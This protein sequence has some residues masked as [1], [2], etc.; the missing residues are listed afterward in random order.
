MFA[1]AAPGTWRGSSLFSRIDD[2]AGGRWATVRRALKFYARLALRR[3]SVD[4]CIRYFHA[5]SAE[6]AQQYPIELHLRPLRPY[7]CANLSVRRRVDCVVWHFN[8][9]HNHLPPEFLRGAPILLPLP[10]PEFP[11]V[12]LVLRH[13]ASQS[14]E[15]ELSLDLMFAGRRV[16]STNFS[17]VSGFVEEG[18]RPGQSAVLVGGFQGVRGTEHEVREIGA[19][20]QKLR[21]GALLICA[22]QGLCA[23]WG[24]PAPMTVSSKGHVTA[25]YGR[26]CKIQLDYDEVWRDA[27]ASRLSERCWQLPA[28]PQIRPEHEVA[29]KHRAQHRRRSALKQR[30]FELVHAAGQGTLVRPCAPAA[31][32]NS[33]GRR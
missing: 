1:N 30:L 17:I 4:S 24:L 25:R 19:A 13:S 23:G 29:S 22:L 32:A 11:G 8:W 27:G 5:L 2:G 21:P 16:M 7:L 20:M 3:S 26:A 18:L 14:R 10:E 15:G 12:S 9:L 6:T 28:V 31:D 33:V